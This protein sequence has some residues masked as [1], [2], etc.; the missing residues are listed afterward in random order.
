MKVLPY[1][2][3]IFLYIQKCCYGFSDSLCALRPPACSGAAC[4]YLGQSMAGECMHDFF[5]WVTCISFFHLSSVCDTDCQSSVKAR[6]LCSLC[7][8]CLKSSSTPVL[9]LQKRVLPDPCQSSHQYLK[10]SLCGIL[11]PLLLNA[12]VV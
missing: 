2:L 5:A 11:Q 9:Q 6:H 10:N 1:V 7:Y 3:Y 12:F 4:G 8:F